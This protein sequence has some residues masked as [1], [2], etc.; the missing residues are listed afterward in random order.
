M[1]MCSECINFHLASVYVQRDIQWQTVDAAENVSKLAKSMENCR[2]MQMDFCDA[3]KCLCC[4][5]MADEWPTNGL[6][7]NNVSFV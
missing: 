4:R 1:K 3:I 2:R 5:R 7:H 6:F